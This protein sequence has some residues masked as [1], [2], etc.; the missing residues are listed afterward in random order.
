[1]INLFFQFSFWWILRGC[2]H[3]DWKIYIDVVLPYVNSTRNGLL[4]R[5]WRI[6]RHETRVSQVLQRINSFQET[7]ESEIASFCWSPLL[8]YTPWHQQCGRRSFPFGMA[9]FE[10]AKRWTLGITPWKIYILNPN[11][12]VEGRW[13]SF[14]M[15]WIFRFQPLAFPRCMCYAIIRRFSILI[16]TWLV[17]V[18]CWALA[19]YY[20]INNPV[21]D[22]LL[23]LRL[24][25]C[26]CSIWYIY[27]YM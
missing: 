10:G 5:W 2:L 22:T 1:M 18:G 21:L 15:L 9:F 13:C 17:L 8:I 6:G 7:P 24:I 19:C 12:E 16:P 20:I 11:M 25:I 27:I 26:F 4:Q 14:S 23:Y 3:M